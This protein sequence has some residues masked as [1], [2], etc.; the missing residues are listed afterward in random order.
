MISATGR[1]PRTAD[2]AAGRPGLTDAALRRLHAAGGDGSEHPKDAEDSPPADDETDATLI[3][4]PIPDE[5]TEAD[6]A[7]TKDDGA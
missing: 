4:V 1:H 7:G 6:D 3:R 5:D 2:P